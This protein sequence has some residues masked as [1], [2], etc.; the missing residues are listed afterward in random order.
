VE[1]VVAFAVLAV[2]LGVFYQVVG[3]DLRRSGEIGRYQTA[4]MT[5]QSLLSE[6]ST[7]PFLHDD[8]ASGRTREDMAWNR[9]IAAYDLGRPLESDLRPFLVTVTVRWGTRQSQM[10]RLEAI[11]LGRAARS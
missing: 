9:T 5:A 6:A 11:V 8:V 3:S 10:T 1:V 4:V 2:S 7:T